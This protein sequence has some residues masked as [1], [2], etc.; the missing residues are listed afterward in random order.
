MDKGTVLWKLLS[1]F[2]LQKGVEGT[3]LGLLP[4]EV[5]HF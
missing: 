3:I 1:D 2:G 4:W 5:P